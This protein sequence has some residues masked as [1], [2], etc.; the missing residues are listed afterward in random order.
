MEILKLRD[1]IKFVFVEY[2][3]EFIY[4]FIYDN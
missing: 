4:E 3:A 2:S 1:N